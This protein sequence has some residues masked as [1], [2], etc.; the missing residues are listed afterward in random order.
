MK[1][2]SMCLTRYLGFVVL[3]AG[4]VAVSPAWGQGRQLTVENGWLVSDGQVIWGNAQHNGWWRA[5]QRANITRNAPGVVAPNRTEELNLLTNNMLN[6]G[7]PGFEHNFGLWYDRRRDAH[8]SACRTNAN[9]VSPFLEQPWARSGTGMACDGLSKYDLTQYNQW[10]FDRIRTFANLCDT[11]G[12]ILLHNFYMQHALLEITPHYVDFPWRPNNC[13]QAT[14]MPYDIP[15]ANVFYNTNHTVRYNLHRAYIRKCLD[16]LGDNK[17]VFHMASQEYTGPLS[18]M[19]F[20]LDMVQ[21]WENDRGKNVLFCASAT[22]DVIDAVANDPR[23]DALDLRYF[24]YRANGSLYAPAGGQEVPG[25]YGLTDSAGQSPPYQFYRKIREYRLAYPNKAIIDQMEAS[26]QQTWAFLMGGGSLLIRFMEYTGGIDPP[27]YIAPEHSAIILP[28]YNFIN[29]SLSTRLKDMTP[30][31]LVNNPTSNWCLADANRTYLVYALNGGQI[32]LD[33]TGASSGKPFQARWFD[34][35]T[36]NL[37]NANGGTVMG[38]SVLV[39]DAPDG[40]DWALF[41]AG[42]APLDEVPVIAE[43]SSG[44]LV[45]GTSYTRQMVL[46]HGTPPITWS[47]LQG[48]V[49]LQ[50][51][52]NGLVSG[53]TPN[54]GEAGSSPT[55]EIQA[56]NTIGS[57]TVSWQILVLSRMDFD[58]DGDVDLEDFGVLQAC[59]SGT[60]V[61]YQAGCEHANLDGDIDVD[62]VDVSIFLNCMG[63]PNRPPGC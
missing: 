31:D 50:V 28:T 57:D 49:G 15:A 61:P 7:Y 35:R 23:V 32:T 18:F 10:Y 63:G 38:G 36:G 55:I 22:K 24:W 21:E 19:Q 1:R 20:C 4:I 34:P 16:E 41:L 60:N 30:Q 25:R 47:V 33:L 11:K 13:I 39:F 43:V 59:L 14:G 42:A 54:S 56:S 26:R 29:S 5:G 9:V 52:S 58:Q 40:N 2:S 17:H 62:G 37:S 27:N 51:S 44:T 48:P 3:L 12:T 46:T 45:S 53:W 8:D 6:Y